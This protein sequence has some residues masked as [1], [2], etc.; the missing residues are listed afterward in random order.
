[1]PTLAWRKSAISCGDCPSANC[2]AIAISLLESFYNFSRNCA[3]NAVLVASEGTRIVRSGLDIYTRS[4][5]TSQS[6][7]LGSLAIPTTFEIEGYEALG[8]G[9]TLTLTGSGTTINLSGNGNVVNNATINGVGIT[10]LFQPGVTFV[11]EAISYYQ[12]TV[13]VIRRPQIPAGQPSSFF[14]ITYGNALTSFTN[15]GVLNGDI[16]MS[17][18]NFI[19]TGDINLVT[20]SVGG[21]VFGAKDTAFSFNNQ[22]DITLQVNGSRPSFVNVAQE[23]FDGFDAAMRLRSALDTTAAADVTI[24]NSGNIIGGINGRFA[25]ED[26]VFTNSGMIEGIE[27]P[28]GYFVPGLTLWVGELDFVVPASGETRFDAA[29]ASFTNTATGSIDHSALLYLNAREAAVTNH[30]F[31]GYPDKSSFALEVQQN[32][33]AV[34]VDATSFRFLNTGTIDGNVW[35][36]SIATTASAENSGNIVG[37]GLAINASTFSQLIFGSGVAFELSNETFRNS[38]VTFTNTGSISTAVRGQSP[39]RPIPHLQLA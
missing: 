37:A 15:N 35:L 3:A 27:N 10:G 22:G 28:G 33:K 8:T 34:D 26:F 25:A 16:F 4:F 29:T 19:N 38:T 32:L 5:S 12:P 11:T 39:L 9:T 21:A 1:M 30:G 13:D 18:A 7:A 2:R 36:D 23:F 24:S 14:T 6:R 17:A 31:I 20:A